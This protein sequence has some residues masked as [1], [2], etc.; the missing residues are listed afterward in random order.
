MAEPFTIRAVI[1]PGEA[2]ELLALAVAASSTLHGLSRARQEALAA[3]AVYR[4]VASAGGQAVGLL[5]A[6]EGE[7]GARLRALVVRPERRRKGVARAL[8][9]DLAAETGGIEALV[10]SP[11]AAAEAFFAALGWTATEHGGRQMRR[12]LEGVPPV[13]E[14]PGYR[15]RTYEPGDDAH[16]TR[17]VRAAFATEEGS[18]GPGGVDPFHREFLAQSLWEPGRLFLAVREADGAVAGTTASWEYEIEGRRVGLIHWVAVDPA[19]RGHRLGEALN[20]AA[21]H[22]MQ[23][24]G[25]REAYLHTDYRLRAA[26]RLYER[27]GFTV[28]RRWLLYRS[29]DARQ[30]S[31]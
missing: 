12:D 4:R 28:T 7:R 11:D 15:L 8:V 25:H 23:A 13:P 20:L 19:H 1:E 31:G 5:L 2:R 17:L 27:L 18:H 26:V 16:W 10:D 29:P 3:E 21:L 30:A 24:R 22:D 9:A 14:T 6:E